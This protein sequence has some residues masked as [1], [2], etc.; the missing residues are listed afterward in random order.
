[1]RSLRDVRKQRT[2]ALV[3]VFSSPIYMILVKVFQPRPTV[4]GAFPLTQ[5]LCPLPR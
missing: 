2:L 5:P 3:L 1:M 4:S